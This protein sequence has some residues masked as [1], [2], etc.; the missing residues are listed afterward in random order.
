VPY[1]DPFDNYGTIKTE[2]VMFA[3]DRYG[4]PVRDRSRAS[5][6]G[7]LVNLRND[8]SE[9]Q[10]FGLIVDIRWHERNN[11]DRATR[12]VALRWPSLLASILEGEI[13]EEE[14]A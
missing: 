10:I 8:A 1:L 6:Y 4:G 13:Y 14:A 7:D 2:V 12:L 5:A 11:L 9:Q 3:L